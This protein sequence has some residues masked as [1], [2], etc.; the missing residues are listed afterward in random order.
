MPWSRTRY[1][2]DWR[3]SVHTAEALPLLSNLMNR[4]GSGEEWTDTWGEMAY[5][6]AEG[7]VLHGDDAYFQ[8]RLSI[9]DAARQR[10]HAAAQAMWIAGKYIQWGYRNRENHVEKTRDYRVRGWQILERFLQRALSQFD[11]LQPRMSG[12][13]VTDWTDADREQ[14]PPVARMIDYVSDE[15]YRSSGAFQPDRHDRLVVAEDREE[16]D[17]PSQIGILKGIAQTS[18]RSRSDRQLGTQPAYRKRPN[19]RNAV[20]VAV[21]VHYPHPVVQGRFGNEQV[22]NWCSMPHPVMMGKVLLEAERP[23]ENVWRRRHDLKG[24]VQVVLERVVVPCRAGRVELFELA[25]RAHEEESG[26][27]GESAT[28][29]GIVRTS[30]R[31]LIENPP[32]YLHISSEARTAA[33][34]CELSRW[35]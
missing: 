8:F 35:R 27:F 11:A 26:Q 9:T 22:G 34:I 2:G 25:D 31:T 14:Y 4:L 29:R 28:H 15:L 19:L 12:V 5:T 3:N 10:D 32:R 24:S 13:A 6:V 18:H 7:F 20:E 21:N 16:L 33:S 23:V 30:C 17:V 1:G